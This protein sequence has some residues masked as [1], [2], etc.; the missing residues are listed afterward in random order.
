MVAS[1]RSGR[2]LS[3]PLLLAAVVVY[4][5]IVQGAG[6]LLTADEG[7]DYGTFPTTASIVRAVTIPVGLSVVFG[8]L[9][10]SWL[11]WWD[12]VLTES[13]RLA[14]WAWVFPAIM[15]VSIVAV[16][17]YGLL[18]DVGARMTLTLLGSTLLVG[19]GEELMFRGVTLEA[20]RRVP[21]TTEL[22]AALWTALIFG[23][24]HITNIFTEG[25]GAVLQAV[26]VSVAGLFLYVARR[27]S[28][29][30]LVPV[31]LH[32]GWDFSLFSG[33][34]GEDPDLYLLAALSTLASIVLAVILIKRRHDIWPP[35][36]PG[37]PSPSA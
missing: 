30:L 33:R 7:Y 26:L 22:K 24:V 14:R 34:L 21:G 11:G 18:G 15:T 23:G 12:R 9:L 13:L 31:L 17:D 1:K 35:E 36:V 37:E 28:G 4:L 10:V 27:V 20:M 2:S 32:A 16:T 3:V 25:S 8:V 19:I 5:L 6:L 29:G